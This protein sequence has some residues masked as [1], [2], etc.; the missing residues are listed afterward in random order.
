MVLAGNKGACTFSHIVF[1][2]NGATRRR[3][4]RTVSDIALVMSVMSLL[5]LLLSLL[6]TMPLLVCFCSFV[7]MA[8]RCLLT[9]L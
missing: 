4:V 7:K 6:I 1:W 9:R 3:V 5:L 2:I 8:E